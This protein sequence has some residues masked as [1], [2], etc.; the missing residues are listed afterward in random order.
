MF[1]I[2]FDNLGTILIN[3]SED[4][5]GAA[6][7][8]NITYTDSTTGVQC[9]STDMLTASLCVNKT[10]EHKL[11][12][13]FLS[14]SDSVEISVQVSGTNRLGNGVTSTPVLVPGIS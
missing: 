4:I 14:C 8:Y 1:S 11:D 3:I 9:A 5:D 13:P 7:S 2:N 6:L 12:L 10:C